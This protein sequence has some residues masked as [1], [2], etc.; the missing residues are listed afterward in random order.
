MRG[1]L[2]HLSVDRDLDTE[3]G[4]LHISARVQRRDDLLGITLVHAA[5]VVACVDPVFGLLCD[6]V[7]RVGRGDA[8]GI[9]LEN[10]GAICAR[11]R[12]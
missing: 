1:I 2:R 6:A 10:V 12:A 4:C 8:L 3:T 5:L 7:E 9:D 11:V